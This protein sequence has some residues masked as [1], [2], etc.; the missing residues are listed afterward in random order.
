LEE[1]RTID[2]IKHVRDRAEALRLYAKKAGESLEMQNDIAE[3][4]LRAE[5]RAGSL[6]AET[7]PQHGGDRKSKSRSH[8]ATLKTLG[9][10]K[11]Q[12]QRWQQEAAIPEQLFVRHVAQVRAQ[13]EELTSRGLL[14]LARERRMEQRSK[15]RWQSLQESVSGKFPVLYADPP[16]SYRNAR[17]RGAACGHY[18]TMETEAIASLPVDG[19][20]A[21]N[22]VLF[23]WATN[24]NLEEALLVMRAW[25]FAYKTNFVWTK[26]HFGT[27]FYCRGQH[28]L[29]L[30]GVKGAQ[31]CPPK[32]QRPSSWINAKRGKHSE[33]PAA[34]YDLIETMYPTLPKLELFARK[35]RQG[36]TAWGIRSV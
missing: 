6:L 19:V 32:A 30:L 5:R 1:A 17:S 25:G 7:G 22:A 9:I 21:T 31:M 29:L 13:G 23:L 11:S 18:P 3:I 35:R 14:D 27:G 10:T 20:S 4:K 12:S 36:W 28:E 34:V 24:P 26:H 2:E 8:A 33:K 15:Q 16:W